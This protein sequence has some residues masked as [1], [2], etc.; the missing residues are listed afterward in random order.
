MCVCLWAFVSAHRLSG[1]AAAG[2]DGDTSA[3]LLVNKLEAGATLSIAGC[4]AEAA[5]PARSD[6]L[7]LCLQPGATAAIY[8]VRTC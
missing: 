1:E 2:V 7:M 6:Q 5:A 8:T 4:P 3:V